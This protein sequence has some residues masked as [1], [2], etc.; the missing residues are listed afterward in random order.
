MEQDY[1]RVEE[2]LSRLLALLAP[3]FSAEE[4][5]EVR[6]FVEVGEY[7][8]ALETLVD[9][10]IEESKRIPSEEVNLIYELADAMNL[11]RKWYEERLCGHV[12]DT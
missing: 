8:L 4:I 7:G 6:E 3:T 9:I 2:L 12:V 5:L 10:V 11:D 1:Q